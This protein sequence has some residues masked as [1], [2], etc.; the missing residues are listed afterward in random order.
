MNE[1]NVLANS[2]EGVSLFHSVRTKREGAIC[3]PGNKCSPDTQS[4]C[5]LI[6]NFP[7]FRTVR[8]TFLLFIS[9]TVYDISLQL[10]K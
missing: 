9:H 4:A 3:G 5:P 10:P 8:H 7:P 1:I 6:L 2:P